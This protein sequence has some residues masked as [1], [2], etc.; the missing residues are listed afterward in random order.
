[1]IEVAYSREK[2]VLKAIPKEVQEAVIRTLKI[3][4]AEY[5]ADRD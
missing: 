4:D 5:G 3:L 1:M 2:R